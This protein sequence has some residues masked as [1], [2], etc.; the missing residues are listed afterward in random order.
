MLKVAIVG[1]GKIADTHASLIRRIRECEIVAVCDNEELMAKQLYDRFPVKRYYCRLNEL[2]DE[3]RPDVVHITTPP[4]SH[5]AI[6]KQCLEKG[7]H[8]YVEKPFTLDAPEAEKL[9]SIANENNCKLTVGHDAQFT[10][11]SRQMRKLVQEGYLGGAPVHLESA[12][13]YDFGDATYAKTLLGD[14]QH[15][16]RT[17]PG[18]LLHNVISHGVSKIA[19]YMTS[20][21]PR[22]IAH[23]F[24]SPFLKQI[25]EDKIIDEL[26]VII[27]EEQG[28][29]AYFTFS[30]QMQPSLHQF[31]IYGPKNGIMIDEDKQ[32]LIKFQGKSYKSYLE[33]FV[34]QLTNAG[35]YLLNFAHNLRLFL[36]M[37]FHMTSGMK[38]LIESF[39]RSITDGV[40]VPIPYREI[41]LTSKIMDAIF[42][43]ICTE[44]RNQKE[45]MAC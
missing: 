14:R 10:E 44:N 31:H 26:R 45:H 37:D 17:L 34:P 3:S 5:F 25:G 15:W 32:T 13:C 30:S 35:Q 18:G 23:G 21:N 39:Y 6:A 36:A 38:Y 16:V 22:I 41:L 9:I 42:E 20:E 1:C 12:W 8:V 4:Q 11:V 43:Q 24:V 27:H 29:T 7:C 40:Q 33:T 28:T 19:E 2:L